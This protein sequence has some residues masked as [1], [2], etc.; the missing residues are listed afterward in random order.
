ML[1]GFYFQCKGL[2]VDYE[3][4]L[5]IYNGGVDCGSGFNCFNKVLKD[6]NWCF[7]SSEFGV[8]QD[9]MIMK[10]DI[11]NFGFKIDL[12]QE[13]DCENKKCIFESFKKFDGKFLFF[14]GMGYII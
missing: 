1:G 14:G 3:N 2:E 5:L 11:L 7:C 4:M 12:I 9:I 10:F 8:E 13:K 6:F